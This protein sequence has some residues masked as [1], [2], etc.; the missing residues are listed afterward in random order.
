MLNVKSI[1]AA[2][3]VAAISFG[4][5][6]ATVNL[7][8]VV[9]HFWADGVDP[10]VGPESSPVLAGGKYGSK[11]IYQIALKLQIG[12]TAGQSF[13]QLAFDLNTSGNLTQYSDAVNAINSLTSTNPKLNAA[14]G[15]GVYTDP[16]LGDIAFGAG[17]GAASVG[18]I[19]DFGDTGTSTSDLKFIYLESS[20][21]GAVAT[22]SPKRLFAQTG[23]NAALTTALGLPVTFAN[24]L[25]KY[26]GG[27]ASLT[28]AFGLPGEGLTLV[29]GDSGALGQAST[30]GAQFGSVQF[31]EVPEPAT[32]SLAALGGLA[33]IR[34][35][36]A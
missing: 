5:Q 35:R 6:A 14:G 29:N 22:T 13:A 7:V 10:L 24:L 8:P 27:D 26:N 25:M 2:A 9:E 19:T 23:Q 20:V 33:V 34:R 17:A 4:A 12:D 21:G 1:L 28:G 3:A 18:I 15:K 32:L 31:G 30:S 16:F 36:R 11:G